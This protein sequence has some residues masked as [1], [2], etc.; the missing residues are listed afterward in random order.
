MTVWC[1]CSKP[2]LPDLPGAEGDDSA[3]RIVRGNADRH[4]I[5]G[6]D[7]DAEPPHA[8]AQLGED[9]VAGITLHAIQTAGVNGDH[10]SLHVNEI[11]F[12]QQLILSPYSSNQS[13][14]CTDSAQLFVRLIFVWIVVTG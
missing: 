8:P 7:L 4:A 3:D 2:G 9:F 13:A 10:C 12:A 1:V 6:D 11:V 5:T 14:T